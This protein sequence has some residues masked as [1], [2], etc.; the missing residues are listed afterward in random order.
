M[1]QEAQREQ[2]GKR[3]FNKEEGIEDIKE[4]LC[5]YDNKVVCKKC[6]VM[7]PFTFH[8]ANTLWKFQRKDDQFVP[9][10]ATMHLSSNLA[11]LLT[12]QI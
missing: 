2:L 9:L 12:A 8:T 3:K 1:G 4:S 6:T 11:T 10:M 7:C 5:L